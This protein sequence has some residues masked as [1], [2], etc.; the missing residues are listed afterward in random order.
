MSQETT[1]IQFT[2]KWGEENQQI[3]SLDFEHFCF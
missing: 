1:D 2:T 3:F